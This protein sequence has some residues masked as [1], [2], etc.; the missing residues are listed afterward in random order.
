[1]TRLLPSPHLLR[2]AVV[3]GAI[4]GGSSAWADGVEHPSEDGS[5]PVPQEPD[6]TPDQ[7]LPASTWFDRIGTPGRAFTPRE[8]RLAAL[9]HETF[10][11]AG[12]SDAI[13]FAAIV[14][15]YAESQLNPY[16]RMSQP[17]A[18][19]GR[20]YPNGT[21][22]I[23]LFQLLPSKWGAGG[24]TGPDR[25]Y[26]RTFMGGRWAGT[27][28]QAR[29]YFDQ[30]DGRGRRYYDGTD[31][32]LNTE[33][34]I[35]EVERDGARLLAAEERGASIAELSYIFGRDIERPQLASHHRRHLAVKMFGKEL[36]L[37]RHPARLFAP[38]P[39]PE[40]EFIVQRLPTCPRLRART[41]SL[42]DGTD[43]LD[44]RTAELDVGASERDGWVTLYGAFATALSSLNLVVR[45]G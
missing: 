39:E 38:E 8:L 42:I 17:F 10:V 19:K 13:A 37:T 3:G 24:P 21:G 41:G 31:P 40:P 14:N 11:D 28:W 1:M 36:A 44:R 30:P 35:L 25:G 23:G 29:R 4:L 9:I 12:Y 43:G 26:S 6:C 7:P 2:A 27:R 16:A 18:W 45:W 5:W 22:A 15:A 20:Y 34:I 32:K 33:R